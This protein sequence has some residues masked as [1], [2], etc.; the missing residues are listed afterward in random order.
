MHPLRGL[1]SL[2]PQMTL[3]GRVHAFPMLMFPVSST[4]RSPGA[5]CC[6]EGQ[7]SW[8]VG[9]ND[10]GMHKTSVPTPPRLPVRV[11]LS[12]VSSLPRNDRHKVHLRLSLLLNVSIAAAGPETH[13]LQLVSVTW[14]G[15]AVW[16]ALYRRVTPRRCSFT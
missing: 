1:T 16:A 5:A 15:W 6:T 10:A 2:F 12:S 7:L 8:Q 13:L 3:E 4:S 14:E 9:S 11:T